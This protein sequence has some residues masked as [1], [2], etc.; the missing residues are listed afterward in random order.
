MRVRPAAVGSPRRRM[1]AH[2]FAVKYTTSS[3]KNFSLPAMVAGFMRVSSITSPGTET[4][5]AHST[6]RLATPAEL[7]R[8][9]VIAGSTWR[10]P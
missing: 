9:R 1:T 10:R 3:S 4:S 7:S 2:T 5:P 6:C 8:T